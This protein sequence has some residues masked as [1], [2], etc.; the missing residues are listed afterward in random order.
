MLRERESPAGTG[1]GTPSAK[2]GRA[3]PPTRA[4][5]AL[6][7]L[8]APERERAAPSADREDAN[9][10]K[11]TRTG[12]AR[13]GRA[14][15]SDEATPIGS[16][17][18]SPTMQSGPWHDP[19]RAPCSSWLLTQISNRPAGGD[20]LSLVPGTPGW[21]AAAGLS[22]PCYRGGERTRDRGPGAAQVLQG[23]RRPGRPGLGNGPRGGA[24]AARPERGRQDHHGGDPGGLPPARLGEARVLG[25]D[26]QRAGR[27]GAHREGSSFKRARTS[28]T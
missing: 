9:K 4:P 6:P 16:P 19:D 21:C 25:E 18:A 2:A 20:M 5:R 14:R 26:P 10:G 22:G 8:R 17:R 27:R 3:R 12:R 24:L 11:A 13:R 28:P 15:A 7:A 1:H 23:H